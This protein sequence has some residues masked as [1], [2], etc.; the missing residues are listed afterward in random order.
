MRKDVVG[1]PEGA[2]LKDTELLGLEPLDTDKEADGPTYEHRPNVAIDIHAISFFL[3]SV[4]N[5]Y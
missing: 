5:F 3:C 4:C 2:I 1:R